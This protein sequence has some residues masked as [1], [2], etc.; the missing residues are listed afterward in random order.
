M[1][2]LP[3][4][5]NTY[6]FI[7]ETHLDMGSCLVHAY[8]VHAWA[9]VETENGTY[10]ADPVLLNETS[11]MLLSAFEMERM[12]NQA[13]GETYT[14]WKLHKV[15]VTE[16]P[17]VHAEIIQLLWLSQQASDEEEGKRLF[18]EALDLQKTLS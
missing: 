4:V 5:P 2:V 17:E 18:M 13:A 8:P 14:D 15:I 12:Y 11:C 16:Q 6:A 7:R 10:Q 1:T 9:Q 3:A